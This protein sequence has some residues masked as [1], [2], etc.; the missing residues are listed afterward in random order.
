MDDGLARFLSTGVNGILIAAVAVIAVAFEHGSVALGPKELGEL[1]RALLWF[2]L[3]C[4]AASFGT[5]EVLKR[6][7]G[8]RGVYQRRQASLWLAKRSG[9]PTNKKPFD[10]LL[11]AM[12]LDKGTDTEVWRVFN[13]PTEQLA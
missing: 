4:G 11:G 7:L 6:L 3:L 1:V 5:I 9:D 12:A 2:A 10:Q 13:L 8:L